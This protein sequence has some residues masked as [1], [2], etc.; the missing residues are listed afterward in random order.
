MALH[1]EH[2]RVVGGRPG[3]SRFPQKL[4]QAVS[5]KVG[6]GGKTRSLFMHGHGYP[7]GEPSHVESALTRDN[8]A[9][10][11]EKYFS[12]VLN[13]YP[14]GENASIIPQDNSQTVPPRDV[15]TAINA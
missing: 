5:G 11:T 3:W 14:Q 12:L 15:F 6:Q 13:I 8:A 10:S 7:L 4:Q 2:L 9:L 1:I